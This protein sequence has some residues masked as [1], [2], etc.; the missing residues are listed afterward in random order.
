MR[1]A[2]HPLKRQIERS[3]REQHVT[4][5]QIADALF[6]DIRTV[7]RKLADPNKFTALDLEILSE[8]LHWRPKT[9][10]NFLE[11]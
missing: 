8:L 5:K 9:L 4:N 10:G 7:Y 3:K 11:V 6:C 1:K 2:M